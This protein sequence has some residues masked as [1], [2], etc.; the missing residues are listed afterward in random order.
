MEFYGILK[1]LSLL[2]GTCD[3]TNTIKP[4]FLFVISSL[5]GK[6]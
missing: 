5:Y 4:P 3:L 2:K 6:W 1:L